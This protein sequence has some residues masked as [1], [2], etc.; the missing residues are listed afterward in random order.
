LMESSI[1]LSFS[2]FLPL[3]PSE[4]PIP[5]RSI[6][7]PQTLTSLHSYIKKTSWWKVWSRFVFLFLLPFIPF[8]T[9]AFWRSKFFPQTLTSFLHWKNFL[10]ESLIALYLLNSPTLDPL[11]TFSSL[12]FWILPTNPNFTSFLH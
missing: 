11:W 10:M 5:W 3:I 6:F 1:V 4:P 12:T 7:F 2:I 9:P 8:E